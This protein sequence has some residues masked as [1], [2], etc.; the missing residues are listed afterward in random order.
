MTSFKRKKEELLDV[1]RM[2][3]LDDILNENLFKDQ[4][5]EIPRTFVSVTHYFECFRY[6]FLEEIRA[7]LESC[8][9][10]IASAPRFNAS[11]EEDEKG[12]FV[13][14]RDESVFHPSMGDVFLFVRRL[15]FLTQPT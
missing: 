9:N 7:Q 3:S 8:L 2:W 10:R 1:I 15:T 13:R 6:P 14:F 5:R 12:L 11:I 4:I